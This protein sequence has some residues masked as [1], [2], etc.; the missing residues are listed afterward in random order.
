MRA[1]RASG[2]LAATLMLILVLSGPSWSRPTSTTGSSPRASKGARGCPG[3]RLY[4]AQDAGGQQGR[5]DLGTVVTA[6]ATGVSGRD[7]IAACA[8]ARGTDV[9]TT[10][11]V[12][13]RGGGGGG[14][15]GGA[16]RV[17]HSRARR[18][19]ESLAPVDF[20]EEHF[21][22]LNYWGFG[23][24]EEDEDEDEEEE[25]GVQVR[26]E[27]GEGEEKRAAQDG[28]DD[29]DQGDG[30]GADVVD[31][32]KPQGEKKLWSEEALTRG[33]TLEERAGGEQ[34]AVD[35][36]ADRQ[37]AE[38]P[39]D[40]NWKE[41]DPVRSDPKVEDQADDDEEDAEIPA[42]DVEL[43]SPADGNVKLEDPQGGREEMLDSAGGDDEKAEDPAG[44]HDSNASD[45]TRE[46]PSGVDP[47]TQPN[48][49]DTT[50]AA[51][52]SDKH[53]GVTAEADSTKRLHKA[54]SWGLG[55]NE[56]APGGGGDDD[57]EPGRE[58]ELNETSRHGDITK[59]DTKGD[60]SG[61]TDAGLNLTTAAAPT[62]VLQSNTWQ[63]DKA[64]RPSPSARGA[65]AGP[66]EVKGQ[67]GQV[68]HAAP[69]EAGGPAGPAG[70]PGRRR[71]G[72]QEGGGEGLLVEVPYPRGGAPRGNPMHGSHG[73]V[74]KSW[75]R[76]LRSKVGC[77]SGLLVPVGIGV[78]AAAFMLLAVY[79]LRAAA[80]RRWRRSVKRRPQKS[81]TTSTQ[82]RMMLLAGSSEEE[83]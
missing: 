16:S 51:A 72:L 62:Q 27:R 41:E 34:E 61:S 45:S 10:A 69:A 42:G 53:G 8:E 18:W 70:R 14:D 43:D 1:V 82:D 48:A 11:V 22:G 59:G 52:V 65:H 19:L 2:F 56:S 5:L 20:P 25:D 37:E 44:H 63:P 77:M 6:S 36:A 73:Y 50:E 40:D 9:R 81:D 64:S 49:L 83:F 12:G 68:E 75:V 24:A 67:P 23:D 13:G 35:L 76:E 66:A 31:Y 74:I 38:D 15:G 3:Q 55:V 54:T 29:V 17:L 26:G 80:T 28:A 21:P 79:G 4:A 32:D 60:V 39:A 7:V 30:E 58:T 33:L 46:V 78:A 71:A 47:Q 57:D